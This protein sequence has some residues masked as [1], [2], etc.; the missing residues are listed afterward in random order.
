M[1]YIYAELMNIN[2]RC[3]QLQN[4]GVA[5]ASCYYPVRVC[6]AGLCVWLRRFVYVC[7]CVYICICVCICGQKTGCWGLTTGK[8]PVSVI[9]CLLVEFNGQKRGL[10]YQAIRSGKDIWKHSING[11]EKG[12][13]KI[14]LR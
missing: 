6:A 12:S 4:A 13:W 7:I 2:N 10:L 3:L 9:Y 14:V 11:T 8:S 1:V 5:I